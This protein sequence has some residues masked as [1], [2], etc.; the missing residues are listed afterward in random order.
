M[1]VEYSAIEHDGK[2]LSN[3]HSEVILNWHGIYQIPTKKIK[4]NVVRVFLLNF[5]F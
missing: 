3:K 1:C 4:T 5:F 2:Y